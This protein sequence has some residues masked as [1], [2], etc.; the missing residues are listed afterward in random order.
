MNRK[1]IKWRGGGIH[2]KEREE[3]GS[4]VQRGKWRGG[5]VNSTRRIG[6]IREEG[7]RLFTKVKPYN[8]WS[9]DIANYIV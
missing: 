9:G 1:E 7:G 2:R 8:F 3:G 4:H 5:H 6:G